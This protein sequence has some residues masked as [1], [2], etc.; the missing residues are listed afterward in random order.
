M[1]I[2]ERLEQKEAK[3]CP[4]SPAQKKSGGVPA[5]VS[6]LL[7]CLAALIGG[8]IYVS[9]SRVIY[10]WDDSTY[11]DI[12]RSLVSGELTEGG[13][14]R[15]VYDSVGSLDYNYVAALPSVLWAR[16]FGCSRLAYVAGLIVMYLF[17]S[18]ILLYRLCKKLSKAPGAA[19][20]ITTCIMP[21]T[22]FLA[23]SGF[24]DI[25]GLLIALCCYNLYYTHD[26][27]SSAPW[28]YA[29][30]G[31][32]LLLIMVFRRYFAF[33]AVA[34][35]TSMV[36]DCII[37]RR[38]RLNLLLL[39]AVM[40]A[41]LA[42]LLRPFL[43]NIL[44]RDYG[45]LYSGYKYSPATDLKLMTR[46]FGV[47]FLAAALLTPVLSAAFRR[48]YR[49]IFLWI[50]IAVCAAIFMSTQTHGQQH[51]LLYIP[52]LSVLT[53]FL[54]NCISREWAL[55]AVAALTAFNLGSVFVDRPQPS[56][57]SEIDHYALIPDFSL[58]PVRR[59]DTN[60][61]LTLKRDLD[62]LIPEWQECKVLS[63]SFLLNDS[64]LRNAEPSLGFETYRAPGYIKALPEVDSRDSGRLWELYGA[65][66]ILAAFPVQTHLASGQQTITERA[67]ASFENYTDIARSFVEIY[68]FERQVGSLDVKLYQRVEDIDELRRREF[69]AKL[70]RK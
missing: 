43:T 29:L 38:N 33:F 15:T 70:Y 42:T 46:Y 69:E 39:A 4:P 10:F 63:S 61:I 1:D 13:F 56:G 60:A 49:P 9:A 24:A 30:I 37:Y 52:P 35:L 31:L 50:Q 55:A 26:S 28:R 23:F 32:L 45:A 58:R 8:I 34:F 18:A 40:A 48:E 36:A 17:P 25:G 11:W 14:W 67:A 3:Q 2:I 66:Y 68:S 20:L 41:V 6:V 5:A 22:A 47:I 21:I 54:V 7:V 51:L 19:F 59:D 53:I 62:A 12:T 16:L 65:D 27:V 57:I 64:I 44:L